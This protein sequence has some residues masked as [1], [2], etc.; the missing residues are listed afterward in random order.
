[1]YKLSVILYKV[2][3]VEEH[4]AYQQYYNYRYYQQTVLKVK[5]L[6]M[7]NGSFNCCV[8]SINMSACVHSLFQNQIQ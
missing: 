6:V 2:I 8:L 1:M 4:S 5:V 7:L 3:V